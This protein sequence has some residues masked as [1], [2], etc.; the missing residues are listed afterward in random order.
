MY[1]DPTFG[2]RQL[3]DVATQA[4]SPAINQPTTAVLVIDRLHDLL[5]RIARMP[6]P[7]GLH[8]D[9]SGTVRLV[10]RTVSWPYVLNLAFDEISVCGAATWHVTRRLAGAYAD[11]RADLPAE[12]GDEVIR[13]QEN[14]ER[15]AR[16]RAAGSFDASATSPDRLGLG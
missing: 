6:E 8:A 12:L 2:I 3:V 11:L 15:L 9:Q 10:E 4:L 14:L 13:L 16:A 5:L 7:T 1:Q